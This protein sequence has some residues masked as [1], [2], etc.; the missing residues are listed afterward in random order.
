MLCS[1]R[2]AIGNDA[3]VV[4]APRQQ[5]RFLAAAIVGLLTFRGGGIHGR[6]PV[7]TAAS[8]SEIAGFIARAQHALN[9]R[10][11][12]TYRLSVQD[13]AG[14]RTARV[15][16]GQT[17]PLMGFYVEQPSFAPPDLGRHAPGS[18]Y[19]VFFGPQQDPR[20]LFDCWK[21]HT[22]SRWSCAGPYTGIGMSGTATLRGPYPPQALPLGLRNAVATDTGALPPQQQVQSP[23]AFLYQQRIA[24]QTLRCIQFGRAR[25]PQGTICLNQAD[26]VASYDLPTSVSN[27]V[28]R[29]ATLLKY[30]T[31]IPAVALPAS[32]KPIIWNL[33]R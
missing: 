17:S 25:H 7:L 22:W 26:I 14:D 10:F 20:G 29:T 2:R 18:A 28:Y 4:G 27:S 6:L 24:G 30:T 32:P 33:R 15:L 3:D 31:H 1:R 5:Q 12:A 8:P 19:A 23:P 13:A 11:A 21:T 9:G 16:A